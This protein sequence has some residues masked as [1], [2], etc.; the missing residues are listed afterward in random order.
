[1]KLSQ[2]E[3][4]VWVQVVAGSNPVIPTARHASVYSQKLGA[5]MID[6]LGGL[7]LLA[8]LLTAVNILMTIKAW[9][10]ARN[11]RRAVRGGEAAMLKHLA[12]QE[13]RILNADLPEDVRIEAIISLTAMHERLRLLSSDLKT[14][15]GRP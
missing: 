15:S 13:T 3:H 8:V 9:R 10:I 11:T 6:I 7:L 12:A 4:L 5:F 1:M 14:P 2:A